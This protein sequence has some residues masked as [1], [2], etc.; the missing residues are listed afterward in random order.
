MSQGADTGV[1]QE[2]ENALESSTQ[3]KRLMANAVEGCLADLMARIAATVNDTIDGK[4][5]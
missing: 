2:E 3:V 5:M 1:G 4:F